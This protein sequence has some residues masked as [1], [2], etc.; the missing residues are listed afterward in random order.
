MK[1]A[2][3]LN[4]HC[5]NGKDTNDGTA[6]RS[7]TAPAITTT[8][9][10][11]IPTTTATITTTTAASSLP[12]VLPH[13]HN[14]QPQQISFP[15]T[16]LKMYNSLTRQKELF[17]PMNGTKHITWYMYVCVSYGRGFVLMLLLVV[18]VIVAGYLL[19]QHSLILAVAISLPFCR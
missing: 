1:D 6:T 8:S 5:H 2:S 10:G 14:P 12:S 16:G 7:V 9:S 18:A 17:I 4:H 11:T 19:T 15:I 3:D 13:W